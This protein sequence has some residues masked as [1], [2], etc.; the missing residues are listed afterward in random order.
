MNIKKRGRKKKEIA[1]KEGEAMRQ[2]LGR[3]GNIK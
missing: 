3:E 1:R 2:G